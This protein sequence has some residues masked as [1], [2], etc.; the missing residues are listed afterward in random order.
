MSWYGENMPVHRSAPLSS[1][2]APSPHAPAPTQPAIDPS[3][4]PKPP[5]A[6]YP[7]PIRVPPPAPPSVAVAQPPRPKGDDEK[8]LCAAPQRGGLAEDVI[9]H[10]EGASRRASLQSQKVGR[11]TVSLIDGIAEYA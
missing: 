10:V 11:M 6:P 9:D 2:S 8:D 3:H 4:D 1:L 7:P 5:L